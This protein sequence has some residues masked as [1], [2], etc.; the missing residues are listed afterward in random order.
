MGGAGASLDGGDAG[1]VG[2][3]GGGGGVGRMRFTTLSDTGLTVAASAVLSPSL[4]DP[5]S[6]CTRAAS[7]TQ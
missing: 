6:T 5:S 3:G 4:S 1:G 7:V 2:D